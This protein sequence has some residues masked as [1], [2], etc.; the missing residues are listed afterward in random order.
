MQRDNFIPLLLKSSVIMKTLSTLAIA[1]LC[2]TAAF[3]SLPSVL[4]AVRVVDSQAYN[5][6][7]W[8]AVGKFVS[9]NIEGNISFSATLPNGSS[10]SLN[11]KISGTFEATIDSVANG[12]ANVTT[13]PN[14]T[15]SATY[16]AFNGT[17]KTITQTETP[18]N[19]TKTE[20]KALPDLSFGRVLQELNDNT[21]FSGG[22][23]FGANTNLSYS[24]SP[25][26]LYQWNS[27]TVASLHLSA[28]LSSS[29]SVPSVGIGT[30]GSYSLT[31]SLDA[32]YA[33]AH[34]IP[35]YI[36]YSMQG[37]A[38][39]THVGTM[40]TATTTMIASGSGKIAVTIWLMSTNIDLG[41]NQAQQ[42]QV[43]IPS[44]S[45]NLYVVSNSTMS[46][47]GTTGNKLEVSVTGPSGTVGVINVLISQAMLKKAGISDISQVAVSIDGQQ[48]NNY[49]I[50]QIGDGYILTIYYHHSSH[51]VTL[52][53]GSANFG[54][55][56]GTISQVTFGT[57]PGLIFGLSIDTLL[58]IGAVVA[59][60]AVVALGM[61]HIATR[62][63]AGMPGVQ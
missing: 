24:R 49:S 41:P 20:T 52:G 57:P 12:Y 32:Y 22:F 45:T 15:F 37:S 7:P 2:I 30:S 39:V 48:Y 36:S 1:I 19:G 3:V 25:G 6:I 5:V 10:A 46:N 21:T 28:S 17:T 33:M 63:G 4:P 59:V 44:Y 54:T 61:R 51:S 62:R 43:S 58:L 16:K 40:S 27:R 18:T 56:T 60:L 31:G 26:V 53:F 13:V 38:S 14:W 47:L 8:A 23:A 42:G 9:Y 35:M 29:K 55:N 11:A 50:D 34:G